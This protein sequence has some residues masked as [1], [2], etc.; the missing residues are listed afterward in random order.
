MALFIDTQDDEG[1]LRFK[2]LVDVRCL[3]DTIINGTF[4]IL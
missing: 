3:G 2:G 4:S 1:L